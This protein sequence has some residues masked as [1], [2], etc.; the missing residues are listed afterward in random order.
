MERDDSVLPR[1]HHHTHRLHTTPTQGQLCAWDPN[2]LPR[3]NHPPTPTFSPLLLLRDGGWREGGVGGRVMVTGLLINP[4]RRYHPP[5]PPPGR[6]FC[7]NT[8]AVR[9]HRIIFTH[10]TRGSP[11]LKIQQLKAVSVR[12]L[13]IIPVH[14]TTSLD[15]IRNKL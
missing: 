5:S 6:E 7:T 2:S 10:T 8:P 12:L 13:Y 3:H 11:G 15:R 1:E 14:Y 9:P 4:L